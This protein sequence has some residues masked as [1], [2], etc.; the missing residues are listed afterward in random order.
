[1]ARGGFRGELRGWRGNGLGLSEDEGF[2]LGA[3]DMDED[4][5]GFLDVGGGVI[6]DDERDIG[7]WG[8]ETAVASEEGDAAEAAGA[9]AFEGAEDIGGISARGDRHE[10]VA[11]AAEAID[12]A[13]EDFIELVIV[14][15]GREE[16]AVGG[17][18]EGG[19]GRSVAV[20]AAEEFG[21][22]VSAFRGAAAISAGQDAAS[23]VEA[24]SHGVGGAGDL[25]FHGADCF[26]G[27]DGAVEVRLEHGGDDGWARR[28]FK[29]ENR[30]C[31]SGV[32]DW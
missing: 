20:E 3:E 25:V 21:G 12:L 7:E 18:V 22:E 23:G 8:G 4:E 19:E 10:D 28:R 30:T 17:E 6:R 9:G 1:M 5:V 14:G 27:S 24:G 11:G 31:R 2:D 32:R 26:E 29:T 16:A 13:G 15:G